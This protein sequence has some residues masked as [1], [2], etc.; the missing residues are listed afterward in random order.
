MATYLVVPA[1][2]L[3]N[4][5]AVDTIRRSSQL[6]RDTWGPQ[7]TADIRFGWRF[8]LFA[9]PGVILGAIGA[10][11]YWPLVALAFVYIVALVTALFAAS[12]RSARI[13]H[14]R[15]HAS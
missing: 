6:L 5:N 15:N 14:L 7:L 1:V 13:S 2:N 3:E 11:K 8:L 12:A 10:N 4:R 9:I